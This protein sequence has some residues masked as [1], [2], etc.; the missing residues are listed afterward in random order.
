MR[1]S[2][3]GAPWP[4]PCR[5]HVFPFFEKE[6]PP[7]CRRP[8]SPSVRPKTL[9][10][11]C[12][13][14]FLFSSHF[15]QFFGSW[16]SRWVNMHQHRPHN[17]PNIASR[18]AN[19]TPKMDQHSHKIT[20]QWARIVLKIGQHSP[21]MSQYRPKIGRL[22]SKYP[23]LYNFFCCS[24]FSALSD[25]HSRQLYFITDTSCELFVESMYL[26]SFSCLTMQGKQ[27]Q[28]RLHNTGPC[29]REKIPLFFFDRT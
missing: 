6:G 23:A 14:H 7:P 9:P 18:W 27:Q 2:S 22:P 4:Y 26:S 17:G 13:S 29:T 1:K 16:S 20:Q 11:L 24:H 19:I 25:K 5:R 28:R 15:L 12:S 21:N 3:Q 10:I 8:I